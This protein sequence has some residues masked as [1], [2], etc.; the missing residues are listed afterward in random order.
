MAIVCAKPCNEC[1]FSHN[2][3]RG[4]LAAYT[5]QDIKDYINNEALFPCHKMMLEDDMNQEE[6]KESITS[7]EMKLCRGYVECV[8]KSCKSP[9]YNQ[10]LKDAIAQVKSEGL[11]ADTMA[12]W[13]F[14]K[15][16]KIQ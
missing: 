1:P 3:I 12:V 10:E 14:E 9:K 7:G 13:D 11:S 5:I 2:S 15:H 8:I 16:H 4:W 6:V